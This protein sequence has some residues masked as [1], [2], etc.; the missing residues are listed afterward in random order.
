MCAFCKYK[1]STKSR[2]SERKKKDIR[3]R[4]LYL[5]IP[6]SLQAAAQ[7]RWKWKCSSPLF[8]WCL[9]QTAA[10]VL[11][12]QIRSLSKQPQHFCKG[13]LNETEV[14][15]AFLRGSHFAC[16]GMSDYICI[17]PMYTRIGILTNCPICCWKYSQC[18]MEI[19]Y[20]HLGS[21]NLLC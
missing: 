13:K 17:A 18:A 19:T 14:R 4:G 21:L 8:H 20:C 5:H 11:A 2:K 16:Q 1:F 7:L 9:L 3:Y 15:L 10:R 12:S 6:R